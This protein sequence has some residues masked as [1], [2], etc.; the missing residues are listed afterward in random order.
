MHVLSL[1]FLKIPLGSLL[2]THVRLW[3]R[4]GMPLWQ[5]GLRDWSPAIHGSLA[6]GF[7]HDFCFMLNGGDKKQASLY[8]WLPM[9]FVGGCGRGC[10]VLY[11]TF[12]ANHQGSFCLVPSSL[13][14]IHFGN[15]RDVT[16]WAG[17]IEACHAYFFSLYGALSFL[18]N[19][20]KI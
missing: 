8:I 16:Q 3:S 5:L 9:C 2:L 19:L 4:A 7:L 10:V 15:Y 1:L 11:S 12:S 13:S 17:D 20:F 18:N 14:L 6:L